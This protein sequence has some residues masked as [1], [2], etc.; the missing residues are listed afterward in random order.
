MKNFLFSLFVLFSFFSGFSQVNILWQSRYTYN[1]TGNVIEQAKD[2]V[3]DASGNIYVCGTGKGIG[4]TFDYV[5]VKYNSSGVQ[6][7][8]SYYNGAGSAYDDCRA[9]AIDDSSNV[10]VTGW[11]DIGAANYNIATV[12]Y[13]SSGTQKWVQSYDGLGHANDEGNDIFVD[14]SGNVYVAGSIDDGASYSADYI[15]LKYSRGGSQIWAKPLHSG[16]IDQAKKVF[17]DA[18]GNVYVTGQIQSTTYG[19]DIYTVKYN[20]AGTQLWAN[21]YNNTAK[22]GDDFPKD[23]IVNSSGEIFITGYS[24]VN[25][26]IDFNCLTLKIPSS[27]TAQSWVKTEAGT[28]GDLDRGNAITLDGSGNVLITGEVNNGGSSA[29]DMLTVKYNAS[30][31]LLWKKLY[32]GAANKW[33]EGYGIIT[34][35]SGNA[36][37]TGFSNVNGQ[38]NN[39]CTVKYLAATGDMDW[40]TSYNGTGNGADNAIGVFLDANLNVIVSGTSKGNSTNDDIETIKYCQLKSNAGKDTS[41]CL[42]ASVTLSGSATGASSYLWKDLKGTTIGTTTSVI[43]SPSDTTTYIVSITNALGCTD[44]DTVIV[45]VS[46]LAGP[47]INASPSNSVCEGATITLSSSTFSHYSWSNGD[48]TQTTQVKTAGTY[49]LITSGSINTCKSQS[50]VSVTFNALPKINAGKDTSVCGTNPLVLCASGATTYSW[51]DGPLNTISDSTLA[52]PTVSLPN[53]SIDYIVR[54]TNGNG[55]ANYDT[56]KVIRNNIPPIP[57]V[58]GGSFL[59]A[60]STV[61]VIN[62]QWYEYNCNYNV[63]SAINGAIQQKYT[64]T[65]SGC[66]IVSIRDA[67]GCTAYSP[68]YCQVKSNTQN[69]TSICWGTSIT[70]KASGAITYKWKNAQGNTIGS[71]SSIT[72]TPN[73][74]TRYFISTTSSLGC[75]QIDTINVLVRNLPPIPTITVGNVLTANSTLSG[76]T[77]QWYSYNCNTNTSTLIVGAT[78]STYTPTANGCY[79]VS[80]TDNNGCSSSSSSV[81]YI[82]GIHEENM[83]V[84]Y[85]IFPNP[86]DNNFTLSINSGLAEKCNLKIYDITGRAV[87]VEQFTIGQGTNQTKKI[88]D[89]SQLQSGIYYV[90]LVGSNG[91]AIVKKLIKE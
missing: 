23:M 77:Y 79:G 15:T 40:L 60:N 81:S 18:S 70:L 27:G 56:V 74:T 78:Q 6:Q 84:G 52:C 67:K 57:S 71:D 61:P 65:I 16:P 46:P 2:F 42:G 21:T 64:P 73:N 3:S 30:G 43:V 68:E 66:F 59:N 89:I 55:C 11:S 5:I 7:W 91:S 20:S 53:G 28:L 25:G 1:G 76:I 22:N 51:T 50:T 36:Y 34:D 87:I 62:Y 9:I 48:T 32:N 54:G 35:A 13:N 29:Q 58:T 10:Y 12:K 47:S 38:N 88:I 41:I 63:S 33:D 26:S 4:G 39:Y 75:D 69:D 83:P 19:F 80:I 37:V 14:A 17:A 82:I 45:K 8:V 49:T 44:E 90:E 31:T 85:E 24:L 86:A 72:V